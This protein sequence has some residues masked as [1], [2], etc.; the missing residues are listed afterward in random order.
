MQQPILTFIL[1]LITSNIFAQEKVETVTYWDKGD[2]FYYEIKEIRESY[3][4]DSLTQADSI[5][6]PFRILVVDTI[7]DGYK[8]EY[9]E[10]HEAL[11]RRLLILAPKI[12]IPDAE[13]EEILEEDF[14][15]TYYI[16]Q[17]GSI[18]RSDNFNEFKSSKISQINNLVQYIISS[19]QS[20][21]A[22][23]LFG[24]LE[25]LLESSKGFDNYI[26]HNI[27]LCHEQLGKSFT[28]GGDST[29]AH[30]TVFNEELEYTFEYTIQPHSELEEILGIYIKEVIPRNSIETL[31]EKIK[32]HDDFNTNQSKQS[33]VNNSE[34]GAY[35]FKDY[36]I[37]K[38]WGYSELI[39]VIIIRVMEKNDDTIMKTEKKRIHIDKIRNIYSDDN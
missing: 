22:G 36:Y 3:L 27:E 13:W 24:F 35:T 7:T 15:L 10:D 21:N 23:I 30:R 18:Q 26:T 8:L 12:V 33:L 4:N 29:N 25:N 6:V 11:L 14:Y 39:E 31:Y 9:Q 16:N 5:I 1:C 2:Y 19:N 32:K 34:V 28:I 20:D 37:N 38:K 17:Y